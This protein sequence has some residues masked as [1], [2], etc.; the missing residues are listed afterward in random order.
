M[1]NR[2]SIGDLLHSLT[3]RTPGVPE[4]RDNEPGHQGDGVV[5]HQGEALQGAH[6]KLQGRGEQHR[7]PGQNRN[8]GQSNRNAN[9]GEPRVL[10]GWQRRIAAF[11][12]RKDR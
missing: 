12:G 4:H 7:N 2:R 6:P 9:S 3:H 5:S 8:P 11:F 1:A 10:V